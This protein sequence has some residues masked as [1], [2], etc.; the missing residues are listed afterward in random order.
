MTKRITH[1]LVLIDR[2]PA[3][4]EAAFVQG[5]LGWLKADGGVPYSQYVDDQTKMHVMIIGS[6]KCDE[7]LIANMAL[8]HFPALWNLEP[9]LSEIIYQPFHGPEGNGTT[10]ELRE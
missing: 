10:I 8:V 6:Q 7:S 3:K 1:M 5:M 4:G 9:V 2:K